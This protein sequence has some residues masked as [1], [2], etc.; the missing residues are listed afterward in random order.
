M[1]RHCWLML[2]LTVLS[3]AQSSTT[4]VS[5]SSAS[6]DASRIVGA[7]MTRGGAGA[8]LETLTDTIGGRVTG[9]PECRAA[10]ELILSALKQAGYDN[11]HFEE[12]AVES[13]WKRGS[14]TGRV[15]N[16]VDRPLVVG[17]YGWVPGTSGRI[18]AALA[19]LGAPAGIDIAS[20]TA[21]LRGA[22][23]MV[24]LHDTPDTPAFVQRAAI[25]K[26]L[27]TVGA[28][29][30]LI[31]S[32]KPDRMVYTSA[33]GFYPRGPL[34]VIS[35]AKEDSLFLRRLLARGP[36][37]VSF[38]VE[39]S[40]D[41]SPYK[42]RNVVADLPGSDPGEI[43]LMGGHFDSWDPGQGA[44]DDGSGIA[45]VLEAARVFK[46]LGIK[47]RATIRFA[48]FS[49][50]EQALLGSR[51]Y[52]EAHKSDLDH[53]RAVL[54]MDEGAQ[55]PHGFQIQGRDDLKASLEKILRP[56][57]PLNANDLSLAGSF[58]QDHAPFLAFGVPALTLWVEPG[59]YDTLH[60]TAIDTFDKI[61]PRMLSLDTAV[62]AI[63]AYEIAS[64]EQNPGPRLSSSA[65]N[66]L[67][68]KIG[69]ESTHRMVYR[70]GEP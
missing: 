30:M 4:A 27:A 14:A 55:A 43:V 39:N 57:A 11:A 34:P 60:H 62:M 36:V 67:L 49:G 1:L 2:S 8:F 56:L 50:E 66:D 32:D 15:L 16:P 3:L 61:D 31:P 44:N 24:D 54:I 29:A 53:F 41:T 7:A 58:D 28:A 65:V 20:G 63:A 6:D 33:F 21:N 40:F 26:H 51:A 22:A 38:D 47:P 10:S 42:E 64:A 45:A 19:D 59:E 5:S 37:K 18:E 9:S 17:S 23:V 70:I 69:M 35:V 13:R 52:A 46:T 48:F 12:Y 68:K 25:A